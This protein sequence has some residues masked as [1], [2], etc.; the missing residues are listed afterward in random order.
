MN[1]STPRNPQYTLCFR[2]NTPLPPLVMI[3]T[4]SPCREVAKCVTVLTKTAKRP[5][6]VTRLADSIRNV[7]G[8]FKRNPL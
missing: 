6:L 4:N 3:N 2:L 8:K 5:H 7:R 1:K